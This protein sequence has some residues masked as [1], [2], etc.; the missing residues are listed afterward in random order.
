VFDHIRRGNRIFISTGCGEP[1]HLVRTL[2]DYVE[3]HPTAFYDAEVLQVWTLG[4]APYTDVKFKRNFRHNSFFIG[5][6]TREAVNRGMEEMT[7]RP[8]GEMVGR[9]I[10]EAFRN[11][12]LHDALGR[13]QER[14]ETLCEEIGMGNG[15]PVVMDVTI[16]VVRGEAVGERKTMLVFHD[17]TRLKR[18]ERIRTDFVA[19]VTH[20]IRSPLTAIIGFTETLQQGAFENPETAR[21]FLR[22]IRENAERLNR[23]VDDLLTLS[24]LELGEAK[25]HPDG[26]RIEESIDRVL[27]ILLTALLLVAGFIT[28]L[29]K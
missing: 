8:P 29:S 28:A 23:L 9:T 22:T 20:E 14:E 12:E 21:K 3:S 13:F 5:N 16:S 24:G 26:L 6:T 19:N 18:L 1:Q 10:L 17:V 15:Q 27:A 7:G 2:I 4:V 25:L 11:V